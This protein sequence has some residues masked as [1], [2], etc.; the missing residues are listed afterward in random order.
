MSNNNQ[1]S[2]DIN[3]NI[4]T[5][6]NSTVGKTS[7]ILR[8]A[9]KKFEE[10][11]LM[12]SGIDY[13]TKLIELADHRICRIDFYDTAG[14]E[15]YKSIAFN[16]IKNANGILLMYDITNKESFDSISSWMEGV[17][18]STNED[19]D[20]PCV[21]VGNKCDLDE[22]KVSKE[23]GEKIAQQYGI[24]FFETSNKDGTN[25][26]EAAFELVNKIIQ[27]KEIKINRDTFKLKRKFSKSNHKKSC[28]LKN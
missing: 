12:T 28:C 24:S 21:L 5:L 17:R 23:E 18:S 7:F 15:K 4:L 10:S 26:E 27:N 13:K 3:V 25:V 6:G 19:D 16:V 14:Q 8:F 1:Q 20:F 11:C 9:E 2:F 22:R